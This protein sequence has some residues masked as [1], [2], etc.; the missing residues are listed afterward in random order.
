MQGSN[1]AQFLRFVLT[2]GFAA[3]VNIVSRYELTLALGFELAVLIAYVIGMVTAYALF[4]MLVFAPTGRSVASEVYR[5]VVVNLV[6]LGLVWSVSIFLARILFPA[7]QFTWHAEDIAHLIGVGVPA[8]SSFIGH[9][10]Y[11]FRQ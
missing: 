5:F 7:I 1:G 8:L 10:K 11:T 2:G 4:R 9:K 3:A 6:A